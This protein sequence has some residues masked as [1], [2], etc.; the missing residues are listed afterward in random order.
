MF[1]AN[2]RK[3]SVFNGCLFS[4]GVGMVPGL[5]AGVHRPSTMDRYISIVKNFMQDFR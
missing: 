3:A 5:P 2:H 4:C 1:N